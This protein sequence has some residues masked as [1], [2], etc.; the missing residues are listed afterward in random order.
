MQYNPNQSSFHQQYTSTIVI[1]SF[2]DL[3]GITNFG[4]PTNLT[5]LLETIKTKSH[6]VSVK[7]VDTGDD[8]GRL[9][10][11]LQNPEVERVNREHP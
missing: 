8:D 4:R 6:L 9:L 11:G 1:Y 5:K 2:K 3:P 7:L 10:A